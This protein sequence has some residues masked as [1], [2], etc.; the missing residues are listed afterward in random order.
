[1]ASVHGRQK[2][3]ISLKGPNPDYHPC[4]DGYWDKDA[5]LNNC[6]ASAISGIG[7]IKDW[8]Q[9]LEYFWHKKGEVC[10]LQTPGVILIT[11]SERQ[12][13]ER[14]IAETQGFKLIHTFP[15]CHEPH[16]PCY[17]YAMNNPRLEEMPR[18]KKYLVQSIL[19][20]DR[21]IKE[22]MAKEFNEEVKV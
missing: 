14:R 2:P 5:L 9:F 18:Y 15:S 11:L 6:S 22:R 1:M 21:Q 8:K 10:D 16:A 3:D 19:E 13:A 20:Q 12:Y 17:M 4:K 7:G